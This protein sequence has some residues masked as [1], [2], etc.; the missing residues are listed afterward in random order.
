MQNLGRTNY[1]FLGK[2]AGPLSFEQASIE[3]SRKFLISSQ[4]NNQYSYTAA[5]TSSSKNGED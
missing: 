4:F 3:N 2:F 1:A 5:A